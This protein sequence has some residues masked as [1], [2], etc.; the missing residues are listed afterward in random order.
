MEIESQEEPRPPSRRNRFTVGRDEEGHWVVC[1]SECL[2]GGLFINK[3]AALHFALHESENEADG[4]DC[5][6]ESEILNLRSV[7]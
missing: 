3:E 4:I 1:D 6:A 7:F 5:V 2:V